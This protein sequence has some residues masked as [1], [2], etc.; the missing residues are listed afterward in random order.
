MR[1]HCESSDKISEITDKLNGKFD[2]QLLIIIDDSS[3]VP[4]IE[5]GWRLNENRRKQQEKQISTIKND[6][7]VL[8][9]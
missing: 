6:L 8:E 3:F 9:Y 4:F 2:D 7:C 5:K 1:K